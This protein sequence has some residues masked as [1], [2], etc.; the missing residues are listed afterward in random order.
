MSG[1]V[2]KEEVTRNDDKFEWI[3]LNYILRVFGNIMAGRVQKKGGGR[4][5]RCQMQMVFLKTYGFYQLRYR[6]Q[7]VRS[8]GR[9]PDSPAQA[10]AKLAKLSGQPAGWRV[11]L[12]KV[13]H[14]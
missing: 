4:A 1:W 8:R 6:N 3:T 14:A 10:G 13:R 5:T 12:E 9:W 7:Y 2:Q 11:G